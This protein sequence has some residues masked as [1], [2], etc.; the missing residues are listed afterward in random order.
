MKLKSEIA[1]NEK[2]KQTLLDLT[3]KKIRMHFWLDQFWTNF[4]KYL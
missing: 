2:L 1:T 3:N 4:F